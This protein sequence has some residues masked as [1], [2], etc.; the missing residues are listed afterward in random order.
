MPVCVII[1]Q[2]SPVQTFSLP[3]GLTVV[4][5]LKSMD[6]VCAVRRQVYLSRL[7]WPPF[8]RAKWLYVASFKMRACGVPT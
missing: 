2:S 3:R 8:M 4:G 6:H 5:S 7:A 1:Q